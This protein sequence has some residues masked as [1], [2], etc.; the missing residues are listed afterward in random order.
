MIFIIIL[1]ILGTVTN[2]LRYRPRGYFFWKNVKNTSKY[3]G[4]MCKIYWNKS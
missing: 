4:K 2:P 1:Y 3:A